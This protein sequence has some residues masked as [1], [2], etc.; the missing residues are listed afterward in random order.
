MKYA[1]ILAA[2]LCSSYASAKSFCNKPMPCGDFEGTGSW[3]DS[4][5]NAVAN[6]GY[7][8]KILITPVNA[9]TLNI[10]VYIYNGSLPATPWT[11]S[12]LVF[13]KNGQFTMTDAKGL[14]FGTGF[15]ANQVCTVAFY[16]GVVKG[17]N[18]D[19]VNSFVDILRFD[20]GGLK[21]LNMIADG[22]N[23]SDLEYQR[24]E[25]IKK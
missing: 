4:S 16:P 2:L 1:L 9:W 7:Q 21:R 17:K 25:L 14:R 15:C 20:G 5:G 6:G 23:D 8:E 10:K 3:Y 11:D 22:V 18:G 13:Q 12:N 24:S 19:F